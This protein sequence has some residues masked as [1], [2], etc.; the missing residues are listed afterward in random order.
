MMKKSF[1]PES[2]NFDVPPVEIIGVG[3][4][5]LD[6]TAMVKRASAFDDVI[7]KLE[8]KA[9]RTY[10]H[11]ITTGAYEQYG[12]NLNCF[13]AGTPVVTTAGAKN[14]E[15]VQIGDLVL[16]AEGV[17]KP[18]I[19]T[20]QRVYSGSV[21]TVKVQG[22]P[23]PVTM[24]GNHPVK[25]LRRAELQYHYDRV[26]KGRETKDDYENNILSRIEAQD[27]FVDADSINYFDSVVLPKR[28]VEDNLCGLERNELCMLHGKPY[29]V[30]EQDTLTA[31]IF[32]LW[33]AEGCIVKKGKTTSESKRRSKSTTKSTSS[34]F[35]LNKETDKV[36]IALLEDFAEKYGI[37][38]YKQVTGKCFHITLGGTE[39]AERLVQLFGKGAKNKFLHKNIFGMS[40][41]WRLALLAGY[42]DG[43]GCVNKTGKGQGAV[44]MSTASLALAY[45]MQ[46]LVLSLGRKASVVKCWNRVKNG[47]FG[48]EDTPIYQVTICASQVDGLIRFCQRLK[49]CTTNPVDLSKNLLIGD[50]L[51][52]RV[53]K[54]ATEEVKD[55]KVYNLGVADSHTYCVPFV[56]HNCDGWNGESF[57]LQF[58]HPENMTKTAMML[59]GGL[60]KYHDDTYMKDGA[61]Y[62]E[63]QTKSAGVDPS[64][65][66]VAAK[67]NKLM[68]RGELLI[69]V[70]TEKWA[71][72]L[73]KKAKGDNI[74]LSIG[75]SVPRDVCVICGHIA[76]TA[77]EH[78]SHFKHHRGEL[79]DC[80]V[81]SCVM[82]DSPDFYDISGVNTPADKIAFVLQEVGGE[83]DSLKKSASLH[84][85]LVAARLATPTRPPMVLTKSAQLL[86][87]LSRM[88]KQIE[89]IIEG[90]KKLDT[91]AFKD[92]DEAKKDFLLRVENFP[93][94]EIID[95]SS[96]K[97][98]LLTP[99]MLFK[100]LGKESED[101]DSVLKSCD[102]ECCGDMS[103]MMREL[104]DDE[105]VNEELLDGSFDG[106]PPV[107]L[108]LDAIL[109][110]FIPEFGMTDPA[111]NGKSIRITIIGMAPKATTVEKK[112]S[113]N[114][115]A[116][117]ALRRTYARYL[118]SFAA[119]N[120]DNTCM[121]ALMKLATI[122]K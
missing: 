40:E 10:L 90:D 71:P 48:K 54:V 20:F 107:D 32:G 103:C 22:L 96:R 104:E 21:T 74:Y 33:L 57:E 122:G 47:C 63:H 86:H 66:V 7:E 78:C 6:K 56:V 43:D 88:E 4:K 67:Y 118:I 94:E 87:K 62:Q 102:D 51:L 119:Q 108:N 27:S 23:E 52:L 72:R 29:T 14:I 109:E 13:I 60:S 80:G 24:T 15:D 12:P 38:I 30:D 45:D 100:I 99:E 34:V 42:M 59:D 41:T 111:I 75:A 50:R 16:T 117:E 113:I 46:S 116:Q 70:D 64:G 121:N 35:V 84:D 18:V 114:K 11:V 81:R 1:L 69:A 105:D 17:Y 98:I 120:D 44:S 9:N 25:V 28:R 31:Y 95:G 112:A 8:K 82:N 58:P 53:T 101:E 77:N 55:I 76:K 106:H 26:R 39:L 93:A 115:L 5:G 2:F 19:N 92:S 73:Q 37:S 61:V 68:K 79:Y 91:D 49:A 85:A 65:E 3:S 83:K 110:K 36:S 97:G 89:G